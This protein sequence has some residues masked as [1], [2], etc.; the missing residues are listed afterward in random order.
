MSFQSEEEFDQNSKESLFNHLSQQ[1]NNKSENTNDSNELNDIKK[2]ANLKQSAFEIELKKKSSN[3]SEITKEDQQI[4]D[5]YDLIRKYERENDKVKIFEL[6]TT[7]LKK[8]LEEKT[9]TISILKEKSESDKESINSLS[10]EIEECE[11]RHLA[12][13]NERNKLI[14]ENTTLKENFD[15]KSDELLLENIN[16]NNLNIKYNNLNIKYSSERNELKNELKIIMYYKNIHKYINY[17]LF[18]IVCI[19]NYIY[20]KFIN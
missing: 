3:S 14:I 19:N 17:F 7:N 20:L 15:S 18:I 8:D 12:I 11:S 16:Y 9:R 6:E 2:L 13:S 4:L 5:Y 1:L 10:L